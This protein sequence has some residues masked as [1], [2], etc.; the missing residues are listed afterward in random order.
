MQT[1]NADTGLLGTFSAKATDERQALLP[2]H[3]AFIIDGNGRWA[4]Q[5]GLERH[6]GH[7]VGANTTVEVAKRSFAFG[8][9]TV[10]LYLFST[11]NWSRPKIEVSNIM[12]LLEQ[13]LSDIS[14]YLYENNIT[15]RVIGQ[16][17]RLPISC[18]ALIDRITADSLKMAGSKKT[19]VLAI[20]YGGRDDIVQACKSIISSGTLSV[21]DIDETSFAKHTSTGRLG[22]TDPDLII[23]TS[24]AF[25]LSNFLLWQSAYTEFHLIDKLWPDLSPDEVVEALR[26]YG[27][28]ER[29]FGKLKE[30]QK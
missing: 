13:Y 3:V 18:Q 8:V 21:S 25:R 23:R 17:Q 26:A 15:L 19:L 27:M 29:K 16:T 11:E 1:T 24:G 10:T 14:T 2:E 9:S 20:S 28:R 30:I 12:Q 4:K 5:R 7:A 6:H 22:I